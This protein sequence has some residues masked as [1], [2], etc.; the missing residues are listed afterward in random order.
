M[1]KKIECGGI[2]YRSN[3][4]EYLDQVLRYE[5]GALILA[6]GEKSVMKEFPSFNI[7]KTSEKKLY[8][9]YPGD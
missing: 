7:E 5:N 8:C 2:T 9:F 3:N 4:R 1:L 6:Q